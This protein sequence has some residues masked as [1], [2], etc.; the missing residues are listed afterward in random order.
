M[1]QIW[2]TQD[3]NRNSGRS[4]WLSNRLLLV[5]FAVFSL[6]LS[7]SLS[8]QHLRLTNIADG[9][10]NPIFTRGMYDA[11]LN[12]TLL[13]LFVF[14]LLTMFIRLYR[15]I[16]ET[17]GF[18]QW[19]GPKTS[20]PV[21]DMVLLSRIT[22]HELLVA[23]L[24]RNLQLMFP[25]LLG[26]TVIGS[27]LELQGIS[28]NLSVVL[29][30]SGWTM[31]HSIGI[32]LLDLVASLLAVLLLSLVLIGAGNIPSS[33]I[34]QVLGAGGYLFVLV[35]LMLSFPNLYFYID[36][37]TIV[38]SAVQQLLLGLIPLGIIL[39][40]ILAARHSLLFRR[41]LAGGLPVW[42]LIG[43]GLTLL[44]VQAV[45]SMSYSPYPDLGGA[46]S[47]WAIANLRG[48]FPAVDLL[49]MVSH[50]PMLP[51]NYDGID[52]DPASPH[53][54]YWRVIYAVIL[55][56]L[57][58]TLQLAMCVVAASFSRSMMRQ[59]REGRHAQ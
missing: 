21:D 57:A 7:I 58:G 18:L 1:L 42:C 12:G 13:L 55:P 46:S 44:A 53:A 11:S 30:D 14:C 36:N 23:R 6:S 39:F 24:Y 26:M 49:S 38:Q 32:P 45:N 34:A 15:I 48:L 25:P 43:Y 27:L 52:S 22:D 41:I 51:T 20:G 40:A 16:R 28:G 31:V 3:L 47:I 50:L 29:P 19:P 33:G 54:E 9:T 4:F 10:A 17:I 8:A 35:L 59:R 5:I 2:R 37:R 56:V